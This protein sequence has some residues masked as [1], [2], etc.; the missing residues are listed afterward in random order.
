MIACIVNIKIL[1][2]N[3]A[4]LTALIGSERINIA[5]MIFFATG[6][7]ALVITEA[8]A[9]YTHTGSKRLKFAACPPKAFG[10][11]LGDKI[12]R[13]FVICMNTRQVSC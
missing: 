5:L 6:K 13:K 3:Y 11:F 7:D 8:V 12:D 10:L 4:L 9:S 1:G 2:I